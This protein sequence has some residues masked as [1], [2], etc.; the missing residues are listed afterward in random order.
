MVDLSFEAFEG[1][2]ATE[3]ELKKLDFEICQAR[4]TGEPV[5]ILSIGYQ[6]NK[7]LLHLIA[8]RNPDVE[9]VD[10]TC[11]PEYGWIVIPHNR[12]KIAALWSLGSLLLEKHKNLKPILIG[13]RE[14]EVQDS[15]FFSIWS[16]L[17]VPSFAD[18]SPLTLIHLYQ[19][20][21]RI[22]QC[23]VRG[24]IVEIGAFKFGTTIW[25]RHVLNSLGD[26][27]PV[28]GVECFNGFPQ[29]ESMLDMYRHPG[30][31]TNRKNGALEALLKA[32]DVRWHHL[33]IRD[34]KS[35]DNLPDKIAL[36]FIDTDNYS[37]ARHAIK[38]LEHRVEVGGFIA[39][40]HVS[41]LATRF[42][43]TVGERMAALEQLDGR[44]AW[45]RLHGSSAFLRTQTLG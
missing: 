10:R 24:A 34:E 1:D 39:F 7:T 23:D 21:T 31:E 40:D 45:F 28:E 42:K 41:E 14:L 15:T 4:A 27:R 30:C 26:T 19:C 5:C 38:N 22:C 8:R 6:L 36:L 2:T 13:R 43:Y 32:E 29:P 16:K 18:G 33:D 37:P 11:L 3:E 9:I 20:L 12:A 35:F 44:R 17:L 25:M